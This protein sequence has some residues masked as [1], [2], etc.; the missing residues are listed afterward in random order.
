MASYLRSLCYTRVSGRI[1]EN[2]DCVAF[3]RENCGKQNREKRAGT[4][5]QPSVSDEV[6]D[7]NL[8]SRRHFL[9]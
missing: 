9:I 4:S 8:Q 1:I 2:I 7:V 3:E 5:Y 6:E